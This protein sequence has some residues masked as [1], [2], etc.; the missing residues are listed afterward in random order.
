MPDM[1]AGANQPSPEKILAEI[2]A[3]LR[4][5][6]DQ[7]RLVAIQKLGEHSFSSPAILHTLEGLASNDG[8]LAV[9]EAAS[10]ALS[11]PAHRY[12][13]GRIAKL[14]RKERKI[15]LSE[16][17]EWESQGM[18]Q[19]DQAEVI[20]RRYDFDL[21]PQKAKE[22]LPASPP[23]PEHATVK[24]DQSP[25]IPESPRPSLTQSLLSETSIKIAL[26]L[27]AFFVIAAAAILAAIVEAARLPILLGATLLFAV[28]ALLTRS[29]LPQ[30]SFA[31]FIVFS[32]LLPTDANVL[33]D[34]LNLSKEANAGYWF[35]VMAAMGFIWGFGT[36]FYA[37]RLFSLA[38]FIA[39]G[40][41][42]VRLGEML[43][44]ELEIYLILLSI[45]ALL[46]LG[47]A[48]LLKRWRDAKFSLP[49]FILLQVTQP[50]LAMLALVAIV[51]RAE[52][53]PSPWNLVSTCFWLLT[54]IFYVVS[55]L[56]YPF[57]LFPWMS[58]A[59]LYPLPI[60]FMLTFDVE[61][62]PVA[63]ATWTW[64]FLLA[65]TSELLRRIQIDKLHRYA[66]PTL[67][68]SLLV[69]L[70]A[71]LIGYVDEITYGFALVLASS[72]LYALLHIL[73]PR[74]YVW[75]TALLL[76]L[77]AYFSFFYLPATE[78]FEIFSGYQFLGASLL[79]F[80]PDLFLKPDF[81]G[82]KTW[83]WP[84]RVVGA[85]LASFNLLL[86]LPF[87]TEKS[88]QPAL[89]YSVYAFFF[90]L[91][92]LKYNRAWLGY[93]A[94]ASAAM[95]VTNAIQYFELD[96]WL[97]I[98]TTLSAMYYL[99][100][101]LL[102]RNENQKPW[103]RVLRYSGLGLAGLVSLRAI[104]TSEDFGGWYVLITALMFGIEMYSRWASLAEAGLQVFLASG[105]FL[106][107]RDTDL[108]RG[109]QGLGL[110]LA[111]LVT[112]LVLHRTYPTKRLLAWGSRGLGA[113]VILLNTLD[114]LFGNFGPQAAAICFGI[115]TL[116]FLA[117]TL[118]YRQPL[119]GYCFILYSVLLVIFTLQTIDRPRW[120]LPVTLL[121]IIY[122]AAGYFLRTRA[123]GMILAGSNLQASNT[124]FNW[125]FVLWTGGLGAGLLATFVAPL[126]GGLPAAIPAAI[127][128]T[129]V[130][131]E[132]FDRRNV[133]LGFPAN[134][135]YLMSY[136]I[137]LLELKVEEPQFFS[138]AT[139]ALGMLMHY[140]L[141]RAGSRT[142][143]FITGMAS[144]LVLL[145]TTYIQFLSAEGLTDRLLLFAVIF[146]QA[147]VV[148]AY[149]IV[150]RSRSLV[151]TP[152]IFAVLSVV[153]VL[154]GLLEGIW[155]VILIGCT[156][157]ILLLLGIFAVILR[158]RFKLIGER[159]SDW[160]S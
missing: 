130:A 37:S 11:S 74:A 133:W 139:A 91:Y 8:N 148:L 127:T 104:L 22:V 99:F 9:R 2:H 70:T 54:M 145:S 23:K 57:V 85:I 155:P 149:G 17:D 7:V 105:V 20:R 93:L 50:G 109:F 78:I 113:L 120:M 117:Q 124:G 114:L 107:L 156:G 95:A 125:P 137:I 83:R 102:G 147:L 52:I 40:I 81:S 111:L 33:A 34:I 45:V 3:D 79:L 94:T 150:V 64:G 25:P 65:S 96:I 10:Q 106:I 36:W 6:N 131:I 24:G 71:I 142:G 63:I 82:D 129:M 69:I 67:A 12:I 4:S 66:L 160:G 62:L 15:I 1:P 90:V 46:S 144:Q 84:P 18:V 153:T 157:I 51:S 49:L 14:N 122:Y 136:F 73:K 41:S 21:V 26:Y 53:L 48:Y 154:Y 30:P 13:R 39:L 143:A 19:P 158:E 43:G 5:E 77:G 123:P 76:G 101:F 134:A 121:A 27:G 56:I 59:A 151:F 108:E 92:A 132:A 38:A 31:L 103:S 116:F 128:A 75:T 72:I 88:G 35:A 112:D 118:L 80:I 16:I 28:G 100:G 110:S 42:V 98:F 126:Q 97:P 68:G 89:A 29:R 119:L 152:I 55:N 146:F 87:A 58:I 159:F 32:F 141:V 86:I 115:Y 47:G 60:N 44:A 140:L 135:L 61:S 138:I